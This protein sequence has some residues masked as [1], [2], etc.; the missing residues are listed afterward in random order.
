MSD[1]DESSISSTEEGF[2]L[3]LGGISHSLMKSST[4]KEEIVEISGCNENEKDSGGIDQPQP[5]K[6]ETR[7]WSNHVL[8]WNKSRK[9]I[10]MIELFIRR[11]LG[12]KHHP[13]VLWIW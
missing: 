10:A 6:P 1:S 3:L 12:L 5:L 11:R 9:T 8:I 2:S 4:W 7:L 13:F